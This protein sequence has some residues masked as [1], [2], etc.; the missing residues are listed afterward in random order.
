M[1]IDVRE[2]YE[3][4]AW[5]W[6]DYQPMLD[7]FG[8]IAIQVDDHD[9]QGDSRLLYDENGKIGFLIFGWGSCSGCDA[10]QACDTLE[11]V[12]KLCD[13]LQSEIHWFDNREEALKWFLTHDWEGDYSWYADETKKFVRKCKE[14]L[15]Q[16][17]KQKGRMQ[18]EANSETSNP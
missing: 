7:A 14:Y 11:E 6:C 17:T 1:K 2:L 4:D 9:Y 10:L 18:N 15:S 13:G 5:G 3:D 16:V 12:Q 8:K